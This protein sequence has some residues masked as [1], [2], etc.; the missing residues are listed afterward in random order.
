M[1]FLKVLSRIGFAQKRFLVVTL[2]AFANS[3]PGNALGGFDQDSILANAESVRTSSRTL[4]GFVAH[5]SKSR[6]T[7][8]VAP[9]WNVRGRF[10]RLATPHSSNC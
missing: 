7:Q 9:G 5:Y 1:G 6:I 2:K 10:Q 4:S 3:S 8:G